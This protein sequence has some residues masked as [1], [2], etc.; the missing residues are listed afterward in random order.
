MVKNTPM[1]FE[2]RPGFESND[3]MLMPQTDQ[4]GD[5]SVAGSG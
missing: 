3:E 4:F 2:L 5:V 1:S